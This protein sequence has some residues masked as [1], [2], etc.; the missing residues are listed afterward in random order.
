VTQR[1]IQSIP[2][3]RA[4]ARDYELAA[5]VGDDAVILGWTMAEGIDRSDLLGFA[6]R[7]ISRD[8]ASMRELESRWLSNHRRFAQRTDP[9]DGD[10]ISSQSDPLQQF[11]F[12]DYEIQRGRTYSYSVVPVRG[13]PSLKYFEA[14]ITVTVS[15]DDSH[16]ATASADDSLDTGEALHE[17]DTFGHRSTLTVSPGARQTF[18]NTS[19]SELAANV[20]DL[21]DQA[22]SA[23]LLYSTVPLPDEVLAVVSKVYSGRLLYG[24]VPG[25][26]DAAGSSLGLHQ[27]LHNQSHNT[28]HLSQPVTSQR[29]EPLTVRSH[30][31]PEISRYTS[32][33]VT[34]PWS[35]SPGI[36]LWSDLPRSSAVR[37]I[38]TRLITRDKRCAAR[39]ATSIFQAY[40]AGRLPSQAEAA[41]L[42]PKAPRNLEP[43][44][45]W[46]NIYF[47]RHAASH[48]YRQ[49]E[50]FSGHP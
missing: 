39:L 28:V 29:L 41:D 43:D 19:V 7:R 3:A 2:V 21:T 32:A 40:T 26:D 38:E 9:S 30:A 23:V 12:L 22:R 17:Q 8:A 16:T 18:H 24:L 20:Q 48:K 5:L 10:H 36:L 27:R 25:L 47:C 4:S 50:I 42:Q 13:T 34:D 6:I 1:H 15:P 33:L 11:F 45:R 31:G 44:G 49:R 35:R 14:P 46:S 37:V